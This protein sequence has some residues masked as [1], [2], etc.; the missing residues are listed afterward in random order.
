MQEPD[1]LYKKS[2]KQYGGK[3]KSASTDFGVGTTMV[4][5]NIFSMNSLR[6]YSTKNISG[7]YRNK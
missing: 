6:P 1:Q 7:N 5:G 3:Q 2:V 4:D